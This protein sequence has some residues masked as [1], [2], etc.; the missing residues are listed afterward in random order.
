MSLLEKEHQ[1]FISLMAIQKAVA[2]HKLS[3]TM[4]FTRMQIIIEYIFLFA[5]WT[6]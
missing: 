2:K 1:K 3:Q 6:R 4:F 5:V